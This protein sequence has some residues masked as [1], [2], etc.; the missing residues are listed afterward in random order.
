V[1][2]AGDPTKAGPAVVRVRFPV[3]GHVATHSHPMDEFVTVV[4]GRLRMALGP[5]ADRGSA[6]IL[7]PGGFFYMPAGSIHTVWAEE[8]GTVIDVFANGQFG[9]NY[10]HPPAA[11]AAR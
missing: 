1:V 4:S 7:G 9:I 6:R 2:L 8:A 5:E 3:D 10:H 11:A